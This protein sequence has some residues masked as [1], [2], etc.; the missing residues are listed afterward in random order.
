MDKQQLVSADCPRCAILL[1]INDDVL[2][3]YCLAVKWQAIGSSCSIRTAVNGCEGVLEADLSSE[4]AVCV[5]RHVLRLALRA[6]SV[7]YVAYINRQAISTVL[8]QDQ[9]L[10]S[11]CKFFVKGL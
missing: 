1:A 9:H 4:K 8:R 6:E 2:K 7:W 11:I 3:E 5:R 10:L